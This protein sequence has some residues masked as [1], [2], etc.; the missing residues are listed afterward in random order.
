MLGLQCARMF[1]AI[2]QMLE[3]FDESVI[4]FKLSS[5]CLN[6]MAKQL[7]P[8]NEMRMYHVT[9]LKT[10]HSLRQTAFANSKTQTNMNPFDPFNS[11]E[12][13]E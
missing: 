1:C 12:G 9:C 5:C 2:C 6:R 8:P 7:K 11:F 13:L 10:V 4:S 3:M